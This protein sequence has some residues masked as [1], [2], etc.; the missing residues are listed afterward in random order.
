MLQVILI[1]PHI[2]FIRFHIY[3]DPPTI[4]KEPSNGLVR[5]K[6]GDSVTM[7]CYG[8]GRPEPTMKWHRLV[9]RLNTKFY[10]VAG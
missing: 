10:D 7:A 3:L 6:K 1:V 2:I 5:V 4:T 9:N 8:Q